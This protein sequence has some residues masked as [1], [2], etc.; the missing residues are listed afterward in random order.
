[1]GSIIMVARPKINVAK[2]SRIRFAVIWS[3]SRETF[4]LQIAEKANN[5]AVKIAKLIRSKSSA[6]RISR[7]ELFMIG[8]FRLRRISKYTTDL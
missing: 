3:I 2:I 6:I 4:V 1:M 8:K 7:N 5:I